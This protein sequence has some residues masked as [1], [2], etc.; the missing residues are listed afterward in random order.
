MQIMAY[1]YSWIITPW[2]KL[3]SPTVWATFVELST[4]NVGVFWVIVM[5]Y[6]RKLRFSVRTNDGSLK[7]LVFEAPF[8]EISFHLEPQLLTIS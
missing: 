1:I 3:L 4:D 8:G 7:R 5:K 2:L 6:V